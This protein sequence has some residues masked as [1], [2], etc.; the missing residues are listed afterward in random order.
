[1][2]LPSLPELPFLTRSQKKTVTLMPQ[3]V[4]DKTA[5]QIKTSCPTRSP[6]T[7]PTASVLEKESESFADRNL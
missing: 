1:M 5:P 6:D 7:H 4:N 2:E 3:R